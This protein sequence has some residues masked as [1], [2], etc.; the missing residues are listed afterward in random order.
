MKIEMYLMM[1]FDPRAMAG[2]I[3]CPAQLFKI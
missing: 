3:G 2:N 1:C